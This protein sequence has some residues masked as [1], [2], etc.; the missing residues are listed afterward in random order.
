MIYRLKYQDLLGI[1]LK[2][3]SQIGPV[4]MELQL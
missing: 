4:I 1:D 2:M 3:V